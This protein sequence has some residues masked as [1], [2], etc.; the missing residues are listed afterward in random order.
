MN[1]QFQC[2]TYFHLDQNIELYLYSFPQKVITYRGIN[3]NQ[4]GIDERLGKTEGR[5][6]LEVPINNET[7]IFDTSGMFLL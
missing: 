3:D 2:V 7:G 5:C 1:L 6:V 4:K